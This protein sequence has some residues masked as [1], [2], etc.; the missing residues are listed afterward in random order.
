MGV[1]GWGEGIRIKGLGCWFKCSGSGLTIEDAEGL[2]IR[3]KGFGLAAC[4]L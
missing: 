2:E 3:V 1:S 4:L